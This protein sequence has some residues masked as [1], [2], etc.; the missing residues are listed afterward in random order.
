M[1]FL[2]ILH[3]LIVLVVAGKGVRPSLPALGIG[4]FILRGVALLLLYPRILRKQKRAAQMAEAKGR[5]FIA[6]A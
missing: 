4:L 3:Q 2:K 5:S 6:K 1:K